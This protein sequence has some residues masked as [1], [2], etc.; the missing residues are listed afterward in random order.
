MIAL[1]HFADDAADF[2]ERARA[3]LEVLSRRPGYVRGTLA[4]STDDPQAWLLLTEWENVG[5][6][7]RALGNYEV[8]LHATPLLASALDVPGGFE[9]LVDVAPGGVAAVHDSDRESGW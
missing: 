6:Y 2:D 7:R 5:S 1:T 3:A 4:R 8:K 9:S